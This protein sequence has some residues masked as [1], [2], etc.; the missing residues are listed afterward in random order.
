MKRWY[1]HFAA[2]Y[3]TIWLGLLLVALMAQDHIDAGMFGL[4][5]F[6]IIAAVYAFIRNGGTSREEDE[7]RYL[8]DR[9]RAL[10]WELKNSQNAQDWPGER[11]S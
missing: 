9:I 1:G 7:I 3:G 6:P 10:E 8:H 5:G 2:A 4:I 11:P